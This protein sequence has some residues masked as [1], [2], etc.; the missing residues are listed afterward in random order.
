MLESVEFPS[1]HN[2]VILEVV[3]GSRACVANNG[4]SNDSVVDICCDVVSGINVVGK[5]VV[6][7]LVGRLV[8]NE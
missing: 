7:F 4:S 3:L 1:G 2:T 6:G 5:K 8:I